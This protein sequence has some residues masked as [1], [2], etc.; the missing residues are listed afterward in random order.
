MQTKS[1]FRLLGSS[2]AAVLGV[3]LMAT[4]ATAAPMSQDR[5]HMR[6][7]R[8]WEKV[9][10]NS[11]GTISSEEFRARDDRAFSRLDKNNDGKI[12]QE[13]MAE[14]RGPRHRGH[15]GSHGK[16]HHAAD[17]QGWFNKIDAD[18]DGSVTKT[19]AE[20]AH[21]QMVSRMKERTEHVFTKSDKNN[22][23]KVTKDEF[24]E[25]ARSDHHG[26]NGADPY[27]WA[28]ARKRWFDM[29]DTDHDGAISKAESE[30]A[31]DKRFARLDADHDGKVTQEEMRAA[32]EMM[33]KQWM[34]NKT[35]KP[36]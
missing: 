12:T 27:R 14:M 6:S 25:F 31:S 35:N 29:L 24:S 23:G 2:A 34:Q 9:D 30:A 33:H 11:D 13:E 17:R 1:N 8:M 5:H 36:Q 26:P 10:V 32:R 19:E 7:E 22:D 3:T 28:E 18:H 4:A 20:A 21:D 15:H 16:F